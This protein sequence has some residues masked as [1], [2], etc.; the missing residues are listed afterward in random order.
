MNHHSKVWSKAGKHKYHG[1]QRIR[2]C[3]QA[4]VLDHNC[5]FE[6]GS[7]LNKLGV[8]NS[9]EFLKVIRQQDRDSARVG[10]R[11][12]KR[13]LRQDTPADAGPDYVA[14]GH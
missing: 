5:G 9:S 10:S 3:V 2:F 13:R 4:T 11:R 14:G 8:G 1:A 6:V 12:S 7:L